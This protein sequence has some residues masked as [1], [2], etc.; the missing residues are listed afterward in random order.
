MASARAATGGG[1]RFARIASSAAVFLAVTTSA[2]AA[3]AAINIATVDRTRM[4]IRTGLMSVPEYPERD[5]DVRCA[6]DVGAER[7]LDDFA[8]G[9]AESTGPSENRTV[10]DH[11]D[12][13]KAGLEPFGPDGVGISVE[14]KHLGRRE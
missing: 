12:L 2:R 9:V 6:A 4:R 14:Q 3:D 11:A 1:V 10:R 5:A 8:A 7:L 13:A